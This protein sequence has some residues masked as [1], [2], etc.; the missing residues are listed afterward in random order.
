VAWA[1]Q[2]PPLEYSP[3]CGFLC[4]PLRRKYKSWVFPAAAYSSLRTLLDLGTQGSSSEWGSE[5]KGALLQTRVQAR[6]LATADLL[7]LE[8]SVVE[9]SLVWCL[10]Q[11]P[12]ME[13]TRVL[14]Q[15]HAICDGDYVL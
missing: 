15:G 14:A 13:A 2:N 3:H 6:G 5:Q 1:C 10:Q 12:A 7:V 8:V 11:A 4:L 9:N